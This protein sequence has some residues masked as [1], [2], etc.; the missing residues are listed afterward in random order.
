MSTV[1]ILPVKS[2]HAAKRRLADEMTP[3]ERRVLAQA[4]FSDV[5]VALRRA[6]SVGSVVVVT[7]D[8]DAQQIAGGYGATVLDDD[9]QGHNRAARTGVE[10]A[11]QRGAGRVVLVPS[12]CPMLDPGELDRLVTE[13]PDE[14]SAVIVPDRHGTG[15]NA[16]VLTPPAALAPAFG[17]DSRRRHLVAAQAN[18][19]IGRISEV[20]SLALDVETPDDLDALQQALAARH[21][22]AA[23]TRGML[24]QLGR[25]RI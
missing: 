16:L 15:T 20:P 17:P 7:A 8:A 12:D 2:F 13:A 18:G 3:G 11:L 23:H 4:M 1:A 24:R 21:G 10:H 14:P 19:T 9:D 22:G 6:K 5:L 25:S